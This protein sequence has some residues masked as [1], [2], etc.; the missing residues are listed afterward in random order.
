MVQW[1]RIHL[2]MQ[3][4]WVWSLA[5]EDSTSHRATKPMSRNHWSSW[6]L[7][8]VL[9]SKGS[10]RQR[11]PHTTRKSSLCELQLKEACIQPQGPSAVLSHSSYVWLLQPYGLQPARFLCPCDFPGKNTGMG[12][13]SLLQEL[14]PTQGS[15]PHPLYCRWFLYCWAAKGAQ[16]RPSVAKNK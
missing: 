9:L 2:P 5:Q 13:H 1:L 10:H 8:P 4:T 14:V 6:A 7:E 15:N 16:A 12:C 3:G 11:S